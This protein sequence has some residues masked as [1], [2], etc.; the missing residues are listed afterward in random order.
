M[1]DTSECLQRT[2]AEVKSAHFTICQ[3]PWTCTKWGAH[4]PTCEMP[5]CN[6]LCKQLHQEWFRLRHEA[7]KFYGI[8][9]IKE[10][11]GPSG[12][13]PMDLRKAKMRK[14]GRTPFA[15]MPIPDTSPDLI[16]PPKPESRYREDTEEW[17]NFVG[18]HVPGGGKKNK[19]K[20]TK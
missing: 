11:C 7:E 16:K 12:Y 14:D 9:I 17:D 1:A 8:P 19:K 6:P 10:A 13:V 15:I 2:L 5:M 3:K 4:A 18:G 20:Q